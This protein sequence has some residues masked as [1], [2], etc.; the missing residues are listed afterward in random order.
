M[1]EWGMLFLSL[2]LGGIRG[3]I[4]TSLIRMRSEAM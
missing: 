4:A 3:A 2:S 1:D